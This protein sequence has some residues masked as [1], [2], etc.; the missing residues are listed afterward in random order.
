M[1]CNGA[2][3][4]APVASAVLRAHPLVCCL[5][6][7]KNQMQIVP[8]LSGIQLLLDITAAGAGQVSRVCSDRHLVLQ[9]QGES[10]AV[11]SD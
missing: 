1:A 6:R 9:Q 3:H 5:E 7:V 4:K 2:A 11:G 10:Q 8:G